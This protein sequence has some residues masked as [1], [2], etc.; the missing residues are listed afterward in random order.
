ML[1]QQ[2]VIEQVKSL[3]NE[4]LQNGVSLCKVILF[5]SFAKN[6]KHLYSD[7]DVCLV[8]DNFIGLAFIDMEKFIKILIK[9]EYNLIQIKTYSTLEY[10]ESNPFIDE[11]NKTGITVF[12]TLPEPA[13][14]RM[15]S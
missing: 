5:G 6:T 8:A 11:I 10:L 15:H 1:N 13:L 4:I 14:Q 9:K 12:D 2:A 3:S 7:I